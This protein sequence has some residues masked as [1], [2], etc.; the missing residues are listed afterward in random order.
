LTTAFNELLD[1]SRITFRAIALKF[2]IPFT[3]SVVTSLETG[4]MAAPKIPQWGTIITKN[5]AQWNSHF[6]K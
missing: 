5:S 1:I 6:Q 3:S 2:Q 4:P